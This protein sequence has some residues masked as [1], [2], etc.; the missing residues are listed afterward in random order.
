MVQW[1]GIIKFWYCST[2]DVSSDLRCAFF[3]QHDQTLINFKKVPKLT[4][5]ITWYV[6]LLF[7][8]SRSCCSTLLLT[9]VIKKSEK[10]EVYFYHFCFE[11]NEGF[12]III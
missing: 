6:K 3:Q 12:C 8:P 7:L 5:S 1:L 4:H 9:N 10:A 11:L 2:V